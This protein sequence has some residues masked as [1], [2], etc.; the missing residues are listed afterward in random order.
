MDKDESFDKLLEQTMRAGDKPAL[1]GS[2]LDAETLAA[3][4]GNLLSA[5]ERA[6]AEMHLA[7]CDRCLAV[8]ASIAKTE[9]PPSTAQRSQW[10][11]VRWLVPAATAAVGVAAWVL[12]HQPEPAP[13]VE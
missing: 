1:S 13:S 6:A 12:V 5:S 10:I 2:C 4:G 3:W 11:S 9:P 7:E 8:L